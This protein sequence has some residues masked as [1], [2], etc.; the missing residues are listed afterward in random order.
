[1]RVTRRE[2]LPIAE[3]AVR[4][5][6]RRAVREAIREV[7]REDEVRSLLAELETKAKRPAPARVP[8]RDLPDEEAWERFD[9]IRFA[10]YAAGKSLVI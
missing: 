7:S 2:I 5:A 1:M 10:R 9:G 4:E 3:D 6:L 8:F